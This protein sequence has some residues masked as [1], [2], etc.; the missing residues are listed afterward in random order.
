VAELGA[1]FTV[2]DLRG[3]SGLWISKGRCGDV[4]RRCYGG[5]GALE[6]AGGEES[7][8]IE[9][10]CGGGVGEKSGA[11][12]AALDLQR[13]GEVPDVEVGL[14]RGFAGVKVQRGGGYTAAQGPLRGGA[15]RRGGSRARGGA[16]VE[17]RCTGLRGG[18]FK[19]ESRGSW[20]CVPGVIPARI[21]GLTPRAVKADRAN[22]LA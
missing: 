13:L 14:L 7:L 1:A 2:R 6:M 4:L 10:T 11:G 18:R 15:K 21:G 16:G 3:F 22:S 19:E 17:V 8:R 5:Q 9:L 20:A 12:E